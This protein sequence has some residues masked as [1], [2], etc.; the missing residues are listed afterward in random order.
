MG[1]IVVIN[2]YGMGSGSKELGEVLLGAFLKKIWARSSKPSILVLYNE[3]VRIIA[4]SSPYLDALHGLEEQGVE[5]VA[6]GSC[7]DFYE[8]GNAL[9]VG[10]R[11]DMNEIVNLMMESEKV[12]TL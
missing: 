5:I 7:I 9:K 2:S 4:E 3:G 1:T 11:S 6:C 10:R 12:I 8:L